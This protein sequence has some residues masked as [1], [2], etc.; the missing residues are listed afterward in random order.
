M[1]KKITVKEIEQIIFDMQKEIEKIEGDFCEVL[2]LQSHRIRIAKAIMDK[3][4]KEE[5]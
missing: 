1:D 4:M 2:L 3:L 5:K